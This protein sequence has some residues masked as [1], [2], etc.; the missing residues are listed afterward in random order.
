[1]S[2]F[3][4]SRAPE[5]PKDPEGLTDLDLGLDGDELTLLRLEGE[6]LIGR[7]AHAHMSWGLGTADR[8]GLNQRTGII[9][10][11]FPDKTATAPAQI[12]G[13]YN[14][15]A[16]SWLWAW[17]NASILP[18]MSRDAENVREWGEARGHRAF[19]EPKLHID[20]TTA[21]AIAAVTISVTRATGFYRATGNVSMPIITFGPVTLTAQ[22]GTTSTVQ[23]DLDE[24]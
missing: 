23:I 24:Q 20:E 18:A 9:T 2:I 1:M 22:D 12:L 15:S 4:R 3:R 6:D 21:A 8:W 17:A 13:S 14:S 16:G 7:L 19:S 10:W 5:G 11:T